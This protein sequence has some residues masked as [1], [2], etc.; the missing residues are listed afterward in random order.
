MFITVEGID[1]SGKST[2]LTML[3]QWLEAQGRTVVTIREPGATVLGED[4]RSI[5]LSNKHSIAPTAELLLF[6]AAR[7]QVVEQVIIP[8]LERGEIVLCDRFYDSTTAYQG[9]GRGLDLHE[10]EACNRIAIRGVMP[11]V[12]F[13]F[14]V[15][16]EEAQL[17][18][19][20]GTTTGE[21]DRMERAGRE[22]F[23]RVRDGYHRIAA[24]EP[25]RLR[26]IDG[27]RDRDSVHAEVLGMIKAY[28]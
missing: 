10:V 6:N 2:Q 22:F 19:Q 11:S 14:D 17:R 9:Y 25:E 3:R 15:P 12:T 27:S 8:A 24:K 23:E 26:I 21:P 16:Y 7:A 18:M 28:L 20:F 1:G 13:F 5:L 4:I